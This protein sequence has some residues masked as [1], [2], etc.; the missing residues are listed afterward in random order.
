MPQR[1]KKV[2]SLPGSHLQSKRRDE[3]LS[4]CDKLSIDLIDELRDL[5]VKFVSDCEIQ[6]VIRL[7]IA[8]AVF[9]FKE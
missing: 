5:G 6:D 1:F 9:K 2:T 8:N 7:T 3:I 4:Y